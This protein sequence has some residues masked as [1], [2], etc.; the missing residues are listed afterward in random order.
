MDQG[1]AAVLGAAVGVVGTLGASGLTYLG[2]RQQT[3]ATGQIEYAKAVWTERAELYATFIDEVEEAHHALI[4]GRASISALRSA[5]SGRSNETSQ[6]AVDEAEE[7][8]ASLR[9]A[10]DLI[11]A[12]Y[13]CASR[14]RVLGPQALVDI[15][16]DV[17]QA[18]NGRLGT[19]SR[20]LGAA[21]QGAEPV[22]RFLEEEREQASSF[23]EAFGGFTARAA[24]VI[25]GHEL[26]RRAE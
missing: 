13:K 25:E 3:R 15:T 5:L 4:H 22:G 7:A 26:P 19:L 17:V 10:K 20:S 14:I 6:E 9:E 12:A 21:E 2:V 18:L 16:T 24:H 11:R 23:T 8:L 1:M